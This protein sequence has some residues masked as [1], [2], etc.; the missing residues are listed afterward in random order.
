MPK[1]EAVHID[2]PVLSTP[3]PSKYIVYYMDLHLGNITVVGN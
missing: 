3:A 1:S 2:Q